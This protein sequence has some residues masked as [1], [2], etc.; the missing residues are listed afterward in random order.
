MQVAKDLIRLRSVVRAHNGPLF[1]GK[2]LT[3]IHQ[4]SAE[5]IDFISSFPINAL[6]EWEGGK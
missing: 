3:K 6:L 4:L 5:S 2:S 1:V